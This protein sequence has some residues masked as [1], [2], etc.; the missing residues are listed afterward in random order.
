MWNEK[1]LRLARTG[2]NSCG[3]VLLWFAGLKPRE[4]MAVPHSLELRAQVCDDRKATGFA[5]TPSG[6]GGYA[7]HGAPVAPAMDV[8]QGIIGLL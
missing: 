7:D 1:G 4:M 5:Q 2:P 6:G 8:I 3:V